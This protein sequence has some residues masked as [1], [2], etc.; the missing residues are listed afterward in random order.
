M[1]LTYKALVV[2]VAA[3]AQLTGA[4][5][6]NDPLDSC[7][8]AA[9]TIIENQSA[10]NSTG[11]T[12]FKL[13][14]AA[15]SQSGDDDWH[16]ALTF[17][18]ERAQ[19]TLYSSS[20]TRQ[21]L[22]VIVSVPERFPGSEAGKQTSLCVYRLEQQ[23]AAA[24][25]N[26]QASCTGILSDACIS[27]LNSVP[28]ASD[29]SCPVP[30]I[31]GAC[32]DAKVVGSTTTP[33]VFNSTLCSTNATIPQSDAIPDGYQ[34]YITF[35][36]GEL[37]RTDDSRTSFTVYNEHIVQPVPILLTAK[38]GAGAGNATTRSKL[39]CLAPS[40]VVQGSR[41]AVVTAAAGGSTAAS[42]LGA[43][44]PVLVMSLLASILAV[45]L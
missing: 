19:N 24:N 37:N 4:F 30:D 6:R 18:D 31:A 16:L 25:A 9:R 27:A 11:E 1:S 29:G 21:S 35:A 33:V 14:P 13:L 32:G 26:E 28:A 39:L 36:S 3:L 2:V 23:S 22:D 10:F 20:Q 17:R 38:L 15:S 40:K 43:A 41:T 45:T 42:L 44:K 7:P 5:D 34:N 8:P 12:S